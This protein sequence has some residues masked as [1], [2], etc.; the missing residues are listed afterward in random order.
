MD[1]GAL[2]ARLTVFPPVLRAA[3]A[4]VGEGDARWRPS[5]GGW[6]TLEIVNH[7]ADEETDDFRARLASTLEDPERDWGPI[8]PAG[9]ATQ[10]GYQQREIGPSVERFVAAREDSVRWLRSLGGVDWTVARVHPRFG[11]MRAGDLLASWV[12][13]DALHLRQIAK[14]LHQ[15]AARDGAGFDTGYAGEWTA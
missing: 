11:T 12:A 5:D 14:R 4:A 9:W 6:S 10:R 7:L 2:I 15:L 1:A 13:H 8:D 3:V